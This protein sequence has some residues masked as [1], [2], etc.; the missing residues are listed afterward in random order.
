MS[1][2]SLHVGNGSTYTYAASYDDDQRLL[3]SGLSLASSGATLY[4]V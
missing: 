2:A 4:Q 3:S 1:S